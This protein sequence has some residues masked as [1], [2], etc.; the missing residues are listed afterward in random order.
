MLGV[1]PRETREFDT[2]STSGTFVYTETAQ[3]R[4]MP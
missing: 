1:G 4:R 3:L 2:E